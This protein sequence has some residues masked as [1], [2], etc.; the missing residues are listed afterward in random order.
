MCH[1]VITRPT[2]LRAVG[3]KGMVCQFQN[4]IVSPPATSEAGVHAAGNTKS[5]HFLPAGVGKLSAKQFS[6]CRISDFLHNYR[7]F[8]DRLIC[9][10][11]SS[12]SEPFIES[13][14]QVHILLFIW[15][16]NIL[17]NVPVLFWVTFS[18]SVVSASLG[19]AKFLKLGP[20]RLVPG[21]GPLGGYCRP[22][23]LLLFIS[24]AAWLVSKGLFL[25]LGMSW[26][27]RRENNNIAQLWVAMSLLPQ[28]VLVS[29]K[30]HMLDFIKQ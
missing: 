12:I 2:A 29:I 8:S 9:Y 7:V 23:F 26:S 25:A 1:K 10:Y 5:E 13:I 3:K 28:L 4:G 21:D 24:I 15:G 27:P 20:C 17:G 30:Q 6:W 11:Y 22:S 19:I 14:P 16:T 18:L